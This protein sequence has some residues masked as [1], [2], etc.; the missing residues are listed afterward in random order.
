MSARAQDVSI[1]LLSGARHQ[2]A[3][4]LAKI[5]HCLDQLTDE[6]L[7]WRPRPEMNSIANLIFHLAGN[8]RQ[9]IVSGI[10]GAPDVRDRPGEFGDRSGQPK[11][12]VLAKLKDVLRACDAVLTQLAPEQL[13]APRRIQGFDVTVTQAIFDCVPHFRGH[14]QE[15]IHMTRAQLGD[16]YRFKFVPQGPEQTSA[17]GRS[18]HLFEYEREG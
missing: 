16:G 1:A 11:A 7:W 5:E 6:Q 10:G 13:L 18:V 17:G 4:G 3:D 2:L 15:I 8:L 14:V 12:Q 9:W